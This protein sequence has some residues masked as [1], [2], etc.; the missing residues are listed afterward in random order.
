MK[1]SNYLLVLT[2]IICALLCGC[3]NSEVFYPTL[4]L[5]QPGQEKPST[6]V[7][8]EYN[9]EIV[10]NISRLLVYSFNDANLAQLE[11][12]LASVFSVDSTFKELD[13][14]RLY[15]DENM[16]IGIDTSN[17]SWSY[18]NYKFDDTMYRDCHSGLTDD[19]CIQIAKKVAAEHDLD[20]SI[21][22]NIIVTPVQQKI[23]TEDSKTIGHT[24]FFYPVINGYNVFGV[25]RFCVTINGYGDVSTIICVKKDITPFVEEPIIGIEEALNIITSSDTPTIVG[26]EDIT[27]VRLIECNYGYYADTK[28]ISEQPYLQ[29]IMVLKGI[30][31]DLDGN[32][33]D[34]MAI[35]PA[36]KN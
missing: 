8:F 5:P 11:N 20:L 32:E 16:V 10:P 21:F 23:A 36:I 12:H 4:D 34:Y 22:K 27:N 3:T 13:A 28:P 2:I 6:D 14:L 26:D 31:R 1:I 7:V 9:N 19:E 25:S 29:P 30:G 18:T 15:R 33:S 24:V 35:I 17:G